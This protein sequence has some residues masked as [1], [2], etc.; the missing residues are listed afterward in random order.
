MDTILDFLVDNY[1]WVLIISVFLILVLIGYI[2]DQKKKLKKVKEQEVVANNEININSPVQEEVQNINVVP[3]P[4]AAE[5]V[6]EQPVSNVTNTIETPTFESINNEP[7]APITETPIVE[8]PMT[9]VVTPVVE[10][11]ISEPVVE[12]PVNDLQ[13]EPIFEEA[14][15]TILDIPDNVADIQVPVQENVVSDVEPI[16]IQTPIIEDT[17]IIEEPEVIVEEANTQNV[18]NSWEPE[19]IQETND[20]IN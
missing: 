6:V 20:I 3:A 19:T 11:T 9:E 16:E 4:V 18:V 13:S 5:P 17:E 2:V 1:I 14:T 15:Q 7:I 8:T 12:Q 10:N